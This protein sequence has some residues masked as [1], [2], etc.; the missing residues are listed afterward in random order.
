MEEADNINGME[1]DDNPGTRGNSL[2]MV[3]PGVDGAD[4]NQEASENPDAIGEVEPEQLTQAQRYTI[5]ELKR[6]AP[7]NTPGPGQGS[8]LVHGPRRRESTI[9]SAKTTFEILSQQFGES[10]EDL[11]KD[12]IKG[13]RTRDQIRSAYRELKATGDRLGVAAEELQRAQEKA[14]AVE[15]AQLVHDQMLKFEAKVG[16]LR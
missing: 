4:G 3:P 12:Y 5:N 6:L 14:G 7:K 2:G 9:V 11:G 1:N 8:G 10:L 16:S 15:E 13:K